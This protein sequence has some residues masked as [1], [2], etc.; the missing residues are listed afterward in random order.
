MILKS[1]VLIG[2]VMLL[3]Q[4]YY[5]PILEMLNNKDQLP[6]LLLEV[7]NNRKCNCNVNSVVKI[8]NV[9]S[10]SNNPILDRAKLSGR[11]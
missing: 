3:E 8:T 11:M 2:T 4:S 6:S 10:D 7:T 5:K 1:E 9:I